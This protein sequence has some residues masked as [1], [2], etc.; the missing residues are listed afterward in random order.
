MEYKVIKI[1]LHEKPKLGSEELVEKTMNDMAKKGWNVVSTSI[2]NDIAG[3]LMESYTISE[4]YIVF[5][6]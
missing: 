3:G 6:K 1:E 2:K 4:M 5:G